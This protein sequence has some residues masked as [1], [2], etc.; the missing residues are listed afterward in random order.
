MRNYW[1]AMN[2][3]GAFSLREEDKLFTRKDRSVAPVD[4]SPHANRIN[5]IILRA[6]SL[7]VKFPRYSHHL[8]NWLLEL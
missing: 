8:F 3:D 1:E 4:H 6:L 2:V 7:P 5:T